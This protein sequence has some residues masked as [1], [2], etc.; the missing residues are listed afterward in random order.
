[1]RIVDFA[2][3]NAAFNGTI[4]GTI[5]ALQITAQR[6]QQRE[7]DFQSTQAALGNFALRLGQTETQQAINVQSTSTAVALGNAQQATQAALNFASTQAALQQT[8]TQIQ[9]D[10]MATQTALGSSFATIAANRPAHNVMILNGDFIAGQENADLVQMPLSSAWARSDTGALI[11]Q[12]DHA[13]LFV[14]HLTAMPN[15]TVK[16]RFTA[17]ASPK[18][19]DV[20]LGVTETQPGYTLRLVYDGVQ[21]TSAA[22]YPADFRSLTL[23]S[24]LIIDPNT[25]LMVVTGLTLSPI[26]NDYNLEVQIDGTN[27]QASLN[28]LPILALQVTQPPSI[29][30]S[31]LRVGVQFGIGAQ[32]RELRLIPR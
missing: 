16:L 18:A 17:T 15:Y 28:T 31:E 25:V 29:L 20:L 1:M 8:S 2:Q 4:N 3:T 24:G 13:T 27:V 32:L 10:F 11:A 21:I 5:S 26:N 23:D 7:L 30:N 19:Y 14:R 22:M 6:Q 9:R 12:T